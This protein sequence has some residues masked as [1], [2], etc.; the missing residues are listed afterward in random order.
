MLSIPAAPRAAIVL[1]SSFLLGGLLAPE[2]IAQGQS[3]AARDAEFVRG[4][5][6]DLRFVELAQ[7]ETTR[8]AAKY[9]NSDSASDIALLDLDIKLIGAEILS[10][11][12]ERRSLYL[13]AL[14]KSGEIYE[15]YKGEAVGTQ[16]LETQAE[17]A[18][19]FGEF[20]LDQLTVARKENPDQVKELEEQ[21][22][23]AFKAGVQACD[24][25]MSALSDRMESDPQARFRHNWNWLRKGVL[26]RMHARAVPE[27]R[28]F[29]ADSARVTLEEFIFEVGEHTALGLKGLFEY[30][31]CTEVV[32]D[33]EGAAMEYGDV[34]E[35][36]LITVNDD[37]LDIPAETLQALLDLA[38]EVYESTVRVL[39]EAGKADE[40]IAKAAEFKELIESQKP[41]DVELF[42]ALHPRHGHMVLLYE[43]QAKSESGDSAK[44]NEALAMVQ[45][46]ND[47][48]PA[49]FVGLRAKQILERILSVSGGATSADLM[50][51]VAKGQMA[52]KEWNDA[53]AS[54]KRGLALMDQ[55]DLSNYGLQ[56]WNMIAASYRSQERYLE[57]TIAY[58]VGL[59]NYGK[60]DLALAETMTSPAESASLRMQ[61][62]SKNDPAFNPLKQ[63]IEDLLETY[64][65][66]GSGNKRYYREGRRKLY[67][68]DFKGATQD[69]LK[70]TSD[71]PNYDLAQF[72][73]AYAAYN[74]GDLD[75]AEKIVAGYMAWR[76][77]K[78]AEFP[79]N[80]TDIAQRR[81]EGFAQ[82]T[83]LT[84]EIGYRRAA[85]GEPKQLEAYPKVIEAFNSFLTN[86]AEGGATYVPR[87]YYR[88]GLLYAD[89]GNLEMAE[90][91]YRKLEQLDPANRY[92]AP[93]TSVVFKSY[94]DRIDGLTAELD[95]L[96]GDDAT[97]DAAAKIKGEL[98]DTRRKLI[99]LGKDYAKA[100]S[101][102]NYSI[103]YTTLGAAQ[104][105]TDWD[106]VQEIAYKMIELFGENPDYTTKVDKYVRPKIGIALMEE[107]KFQQAY[108]MLSA[109]MEARPNNYELKRL[110]AR[111][112]GGWLEVDDYGQ[113]VVKLG[114]ERFPEAYT[115]MTEYR[116]YVINP[117]KERYTYE[118]YEYHFETMWFCI[119][120]AK[121]DDKYSNWARRLYSSAKSRD[122]F[123]K[124][125]ALGAKG[126]VLEQK[127]RRNAQ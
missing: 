79:K 93:L 72:Y 33:L 4:L 105:L 74:G 49:D 26:Q 62:A 44:V 8:L 39:L 70:V 2:A 125:R 13:Q 10:N 5:A 3:Q 59:K 7:E 108:D 53:R 95:G 1:F 85:G 55:K 52:E 96:K 73:A 31:Q 81:R 124:L 32:G 120:A 126:R 71:F 37:T 127:F 89:M 35:Q 97:G 12:E 119:Q 25:L 46:I 110:V 87:S 80:R 34:V 116:N 57:A 68:Q 75:Q 64:G 117:D 114:L 48:H 58:K 36:I 45:K 91:Q 18:F 23:T 77:T 60:T 101:S 76:G 56:V 17:A 40:A 61:A 29:L 14:K 54:L 67:A 9:K 112:L 106:G 41:K 118:W 38:Q 90:Q 20:L 30:F 15:A 82:C 69:F 88:L 50:I 65:G 22:N 28:E 103:L 66:T 121:K 42:A 109:A 43:A 63:D 51:E 21:A 98:T 122:D 24:G 102:P 92:L 83:W 84:A 113:P 16:A 47:A 123:G 107:D 104:D 100:S 6:K 115:L 94:S 27:N 19:E 86:H 99:T 111:C 78:D 11:S